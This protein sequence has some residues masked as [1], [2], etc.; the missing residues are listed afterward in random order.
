MIKIYKIL[1]FKADGFFKVYC[2]LEIWDTEP[3]IILVDRKEFF[4]SGVFI[5]IS[6]IGVVGCFSSSSSGSENCSLPK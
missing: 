4:I 6:F 3:T 1:K 2:L 5:I